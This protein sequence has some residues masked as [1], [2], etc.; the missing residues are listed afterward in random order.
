MNP[1]SHH[2]ACNYQ[3]AIFTVNSISSQLSSNQLISFNI[4]LG[5]IKTCRQRGSGYGMEF[6]L[7]E[8]ITQLAHRNEKTHVLK[9][10][11]ALEPLVVA[12]KLRGAWL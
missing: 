8:T 9:L 5:H 6:G 1:K 12:A 7:N 4:G 2:Q 10:L 3:Q 11:L